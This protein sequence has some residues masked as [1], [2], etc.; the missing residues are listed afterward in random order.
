M[1]HN[2]VLNEQVLEII[3][4]HKLQLVQKTLCSGKNM[5]TDA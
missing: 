2:I 3:K 4:L 1:V 5:S